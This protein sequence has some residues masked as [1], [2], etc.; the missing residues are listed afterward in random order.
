MEL[1][2]H[3]SD[4]TQIGLIEGVDSI[5]WN[6]RFDRPGDFEI[7]TNVTMEFLETFKIGRYLSNS[8]LGS[9]SWMIIEGVEIVTD[10]SIGN[11][12]IVT[13]RSL[14]SLLDRRLIIPQLLIDSSLAVAISDLINNN[15][16]S[17]TD[18]LRDIS[19]FRYIEVSGGVFDTAV[20]TQF[21]DQDTLLYAVTSLCNQHDIG[22]SIEYNAT[23]DKFDIT[24]NAGEDRTYSQSTNAFVIFSPEFDNLSSSRYKESLK[25]FKTFCL[26]KGD[27]SDGPA[28]K[29]ESFLGSPT[30]SGLSRREVFLDQTNLSEYIG[31]TEN[32]I[33]TADYEAQLEQKGDLLLKDLNVTSSF[34]GEVEATKMFTYG[35]DFNIGDIV[36]FADEYGNSGTAKV[37]EFIINRSLSGFSTHPIFYMLD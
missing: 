12:L 4:R 11:K 34:D 20:E 14:E 6:E 19:E 18:S 8:T 10:F 30:I 37:V 36:Q 3:E 2:L 27:S 16:I 29:V 17:A 32:K 31:D 21:D 7:Y 26:T 9:N 28:T 5:L 35:V 13:G 24:L 25:A 1:I 23:L 22:F 33:P 15:V